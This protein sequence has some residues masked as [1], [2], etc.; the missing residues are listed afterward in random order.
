MVCPVDADGGATRMSETGRPSRSLPPSGAPAAASAS[1]TG[2]RERDEA[3]VLPISD[4][5]SAGVPETAII[6][7][8]PS[9]RNTVAKIESYKDSRIRGSFIYRT[10]LSDT[11][12]NPL[13]PGVAPHSIVDTKSSFPALRRRALRFR[14]C[15]PHAAARERSG[16]ALSRA[17]RFEPVRRRLRAR[18]RYKPPRSHRRD[19]VPDSNRASRR[20]TLRSEPL[21]LRTPRTGNG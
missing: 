14:T 17:K 1:G 21:T 12:R 18:V 6:N 15:L 2:S 13:R 9:S 4:A 11:A 3:G 5:R 8:L 10:S 7:H 20:G 19:S 16:G